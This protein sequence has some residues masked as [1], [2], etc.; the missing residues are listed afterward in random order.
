MQSANEGF[1]GDGQNA[2]ARA[3]HCRSTANFDSTGSQGIDNQGID[4]RSFSLGKLRLFRASGF[5]A[6]F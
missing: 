4:S 1:E 2:P 6:S 5:R 3:R